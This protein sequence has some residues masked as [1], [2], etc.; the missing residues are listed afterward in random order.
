MFGMVREQVEYGMDLSPIGGPNSV[1]VYKHHLPIS[2]LASIGHTH[3]PLLFFLWLA[4]H[5]QCRH[6]DVESEEFSTT[7]VGLHLVA[8]L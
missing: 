7:P 8:C 3:V 4:E 2:I 6:H 1:I 5:V